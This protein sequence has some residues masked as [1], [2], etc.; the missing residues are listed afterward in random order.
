MA[1]DAA[2]ALPAFL[3]L[4]VDWLVSAGV[5]AASEAPNHCL[6]NEYRDGA[7]I[8]PHDDGPLYLDKVCKLVAEPC[9]CPSPVQAL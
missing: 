8:P 4:V 5:Y 1:P 9:T 7:G 3:Q 2:Q 6:V